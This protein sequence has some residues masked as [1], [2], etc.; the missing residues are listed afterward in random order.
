MREEEGEKR[1]R[2]KEGYVWGQKLGS[3][4]TDMETAERKDIQNESKV[5][6]P[7]AKHR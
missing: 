1:I 3:Y 6:S 7:K 5:K 4:Q 2:E